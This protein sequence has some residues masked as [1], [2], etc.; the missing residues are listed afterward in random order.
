MSY[1]VS[2]DEVLPISDRIVG[3][4][5]PGRRGSPERPRRAGDDSNHGEKRD[6]APPIWTEEVA[7][8]H[9]MAQL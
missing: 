4:L 1:W 9:S 3:W 8:K 7:T 2:M 5:Q 6:W